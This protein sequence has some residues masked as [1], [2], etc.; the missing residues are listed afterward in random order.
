MITRQPT[1][2]DWSKL[3]DMF[4]TEMIA[5]WMVRSKDD[6]NWI[7]YTTI[8]HKAVIAALLGVFNKE[9]KELELGLFLQPE[10]KPDIGN[11]LINKV[12]KEVIPDTEVIT[13]MGDA[14]DQKA[15]KELNFKPVLI[16]YRR[17][18][19]DHLFGDL[20]SHDRREVN[21]K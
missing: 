4:G 17:V 6:P 1:F 5:D 14:K 20:Q 8:E 12:I 10:G 15:F 7:A 19:S 3:S 13:L 16:T 18:I 9:T 21:G 2:N 11:Y